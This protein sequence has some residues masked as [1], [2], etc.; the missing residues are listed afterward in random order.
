MYGVVYFLNTQCNVVTSS[1]TD[2]HRRR[3]PKF[4]LVH[5]GGITYTKALKEKKNYKNMLEFYR[6]DPN[7]TEEKKSNRILAPMRLT[8]EADQ[9]H[10]RTWGRI[11]HPGWNSPHYRSSS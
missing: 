2:Q 4:V 11:R 6:K 9:L 3:D 7:H 8:L 1:F 5:I 10:Q